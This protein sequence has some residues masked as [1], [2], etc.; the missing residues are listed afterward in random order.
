M[1]EN[2]NH[3]HIY[4][5]ADFYKCEIDIRSAFQ[6]KTCK[7]WLS[8]RFLTVNLT[9]TCKLYMYF[10][11][12]KSRVQNVRRLIGR[13]RLGRLRFMGLCNH[14][15][16]NKLKYILSFLFMISGVMRA[17]VARLYI[18]QSGP[19]LQNLFNLVWNTPILW[20]HMNKNHVFW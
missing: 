18:T 7:F 19:F 8:C 1:S 6:Y 14:L 5:L 2:F 16:Y 3:L 12:T 4:K 9:G 20:V 17:F 10:H 11:V 15:C 13:C